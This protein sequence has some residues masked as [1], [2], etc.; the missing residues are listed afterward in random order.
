MESGFQGF[1]LEILIC[2]TIHVQV[3]KKSLK[4]KNFKLYSVKIH[5]RPNK[6]S[7]NNF[8]SIACN[9]KDSQERKMDSHLLTE[10]NKNC[11]VNICLNLLSRYKKKKFLHKVIT[12]DE[13]C[14]VYDSPKRRNS[15]I[16]PG[17][18]SPSFHDKKVLL[19][20]WWDW[21]GIIH[22]ELLERGQT[23]TGERYKAQVNKLADV[24]KENKPFTGQGKWN[25]VD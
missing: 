14:I 1:V 7:E 5:V 23:F 16:D 13:K 11:R 24:L 4:M 22:Y 21:K 9:R 8:K 20:V 12:W 17:Q 15:W 10:E 25:K 2:K 3:L 6:N 19:C 18:P